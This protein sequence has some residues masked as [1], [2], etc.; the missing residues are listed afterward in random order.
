MARVSVGNE[1]FRQQGRRK[2][3]NHEAYYEDHPQDVNDHRTENNDSIQEELVRM[4]QAKEEAEKRAAQLD[5]ELTAL[6][7]QTLKN[8]VMES[9]SQFERDLDEKYHEIKNAI[10]DF[11][12]GLGS[13]EKENETPLKPEEP[14][15]RPPDEQSTM[16]GIPWG[17]PRTA[18]K[19]PWSSGLE[20]TPLPRKVVSLAG[21]K[22]V[23]ELG[24]RFPIYEDP[25]K[26]KTNTN[27]SLLP[28]KNVEAFQDEPV[29][30]AEFQSI[31]AQ[32]K[33][34]V[35]QVKEEPTKPRPRRRTR[36]SPLT[37][38]STY[39]NEA[40]NAEEVGGKVFDFVEQDHLLSQA[41][42]LGKRRR[43]A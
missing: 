26:Q 23:P 41:Q 43:R 17:L 12:A 42:S 36:R 7:S 10:A 33:V 27:S 35:K 37:N 21:K 20:S 11:K 38:I 1:Y 39:G 18:E 40:E 31:F 15:E 19:R 32:P 8:D 5:T 28:L 3:S 22:L 25:P 6:K 29:E 4:K 16:L 34:P 2:L 9:L 30:N 14:N 13:S 24:K